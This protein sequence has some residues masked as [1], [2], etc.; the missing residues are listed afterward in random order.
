MASSAPE[1]SAVYGPV[2][3]WRFG[4]SLGID[5]IGEEST[6][7]FNCV[8]CQLGEIQN[9]TRER[10]VYVATSI[11]ER[12]LERVDW[13]A[14][15][16][17]T[18]SGSGEPTLA[19]NLEEIV[20]A[21]R[22]RAPVPIH[23]LTNATQFEDAEVRRAV[24]GI[25]VVTCKLDAA[26]DSMLRKINRPADGVTLEGIVAGIMK[27]KEE[28]QGRLELQ[29]MFMPMNKGEVD[30]L[31][32]LIRRIDPAEVQLNTPRRPYPTEWH[33]ETRGAHDRKDFEWPTRTLATVG[34]DE[35]RE[36]EERIFKATGVAI[37][38]IYRS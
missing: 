2:R 3:S 19:A 11:V 24:A 6:C 27:L 5:P 4:Q 15:D 18:I 8:Y 23:I 1:F 12:D 16:V 28:Y 30:D 10:K 31:I 33:L 36:I 34:E 22:A 29:V 35:A 25:D 37:V 38:S 26:S 14:V 13:D 32:E 17:V 7:S 20:A 9:V 21:I